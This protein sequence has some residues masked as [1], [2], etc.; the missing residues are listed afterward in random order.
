MVAVG[1]WWL[2]E[3]QEVVEIDVDDGDGD[4]GVVEGDGNA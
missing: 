4:D 2:M 1:R 3:L